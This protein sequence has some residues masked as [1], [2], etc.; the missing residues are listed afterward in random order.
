MNSH[1]SADLP[2]LNAPSPETLDEARA[3]EF[4]PPIGQWLTYG[5]LAIVLAIGAAIP[6]SSFVKY[7]VTVRAE[8]TVRPAGELR[9]L[10]AATE[11]QIQAISA[12]EG[13]H[14][15]AGDQ[16]A[17]V[18]DSRLQTRRVQLESNFQQLQSQMRQ[19]DAQVATMNAQIAAE[20]GRN[21]QA[22][23]VA[24]STLEQS[25]R[26]YEDKQATTVTEMTAAESKLA[27]AQTTLA[28]AK[29]KRDRYQ[30]LAEKG[31]VSL[32][33]YD[34]AQLEV[35]QQEQAVKTAQAEL[36][37]AQA[38]MNPSSAEV[39]AV[40]QQVAQ[41][42][43]GGEATAT[44]LEREQEALL[45][46]KSELIKQASQDEQELE[47]IIHDLKQTTLRAAVAGTVSQMRL[48]NVGQT[49]Q[50]GEVIGYIAP[51]DAPLEV[52][53]AVSTQ[54]ISKLEVDQPVKMR[55][56]A[57]PYPDYGT[58]SGVVTQISKDTTKPNSPNDGSSQPTEV[59]P[60]TYE[61]TV[62]PE[63]NTFGRGDKQCT[64]Q[65][66]MDGRTDIITKEETVLQFFLRKAK[67]IADV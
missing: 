32:L 25:R 47:Q 24:Q 34:E 5:S 15:E 56:S 13:Q 67:L 37:H 51:S 49:V 53:A 3:E 59:T 65:M 22:V 19:V 44:A 48:R 18:D 4:L 46:Q 8:S 7:K 40:A 1:Y 64:L 55:V 14:V 21:R 9:L 50:T 33:Q 11:G 28:A 43:F 20:A 58:L 60:P 36:E 54:N 2:Q 52:K 31:A 41:A 35:E 12:K 45:Q 39:N 61:V 29:V 26:D 10:Q 63:S 27:T 38:M 6:I 57:C 30:G 42:Q 16:I 17:T 66:G 23:T 62:T